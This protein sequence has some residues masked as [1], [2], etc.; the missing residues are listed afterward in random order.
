MRKGKR[1]ILN[2]AW[3]TP[4]LAAAKKRNA[5]ERTNGKTKTKKKPKKKHNPSNHSHAWR[6]HTIAGS[7]HTTF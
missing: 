3:P 5:N 6:K 1:Y 2:S 7:I 4:D